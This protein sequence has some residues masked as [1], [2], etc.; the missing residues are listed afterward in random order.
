MAKTEI[1]I[2]VAVP[3]SG[4]SAPLGLEVKQA[5]EIAV[6]EWNTLGGLAGIPVRLL[7]VDDQSSV[8]LAEEAA[9]MLCKEENVLG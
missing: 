4:L 6:D 2:G 8:D 3:L 7:T 1:R 5:V 9:K